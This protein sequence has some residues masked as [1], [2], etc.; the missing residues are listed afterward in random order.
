MNARILSSIPT[1]YEYTV[2][3]SYF[4]LFSVSVVRRRLN[5]IKIQTWEYLHVR[6][7]FDSF[8]TSRLII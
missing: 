5:V 2:H 3:L 6:I 8:V 4:Q 7:N 1:S